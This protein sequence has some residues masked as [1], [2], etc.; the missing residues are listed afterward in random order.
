[1]RARMC[2][3][4]CVC[5]ISMPS[6]PKAMEIGSSKQALKIYSTVLKYGTTTPIYFF[7]LVN[8]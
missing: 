5:T 1:M 8:S 6:T 2:V 4:M 7:F 3:C